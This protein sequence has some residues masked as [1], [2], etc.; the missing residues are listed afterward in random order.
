[1]PDSNKSNAKSND[2]IPANNTSILKQQYSNDNTAILC[3]WC[4]RTLAGALRA[5]GARCARPNVIT[6]I[7][8]LVLLCYHYCVVTLQYWYL[9]WCCY[10]HFLRLPHSL[11]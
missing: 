9:Y 8:F 1:M 11:H 5:P 4:S 6:S 2:N 10:S 7:V 3:E